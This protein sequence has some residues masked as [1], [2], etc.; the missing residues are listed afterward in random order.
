MTLRRGFKAEAERL[1]EDVRGD[2]GLAPDEP[3]VPRAV[4]AHLGVEVRMGDELVSRARFAELEQ[5]QPGAFSACTFRPSAE[6]VV[7]VLNPLSSDARRNSDLAHELAHVL[8]NHELSRLE[9]VADLSFLVCDA[10]QEEEAA[11]LSGCLLLPRLLLL[12]H[13]RRGV[14]AHDLAAQ[15]CISEHMVTYRINVTGVRRQLAGH[16]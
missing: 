15:L 12:S 11:W 5:I 8:L 14:T 16:T 9:R 13:L 4:A 10:D 6:R 7:V 3:A 1:A 2:M